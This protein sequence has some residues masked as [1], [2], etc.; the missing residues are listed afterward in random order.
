MS[1]FTLRF[2][3]AEGTVEAT[4]LVQLWSGPFEVEVSSPWITVRDARGP[5]VRLEV[6]DLATELGSSCAAGVRHLAE[7]HGTGD[8]IE[9]ITFVLDHSSAIVVARPILT[10]DGDIE[11]S[12]D[13]LDVL[14]DWLFEE[15]GGVLQ[16][17]GEGIYGEEGLLI[18]LP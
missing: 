8:A 17:D 16:I 14:W 9:A 2:I 1:S 18:Q 5:L 12:L 15:R 10:E 13:P 4:D 3:I 7:Q 11:R 6:L